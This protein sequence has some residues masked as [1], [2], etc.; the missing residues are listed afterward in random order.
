[1]T[2]HEVELSV[3]KNLIEIFDS[4]V[5]QFDIEVHLNGI[6]P[7]KPK[8]IGRRVDTGNATTRSGHS[9]SLRSLPTT[10]IEYGH[11]GLDLGVDLSG[12]DFLP[13]YVSKVS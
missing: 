10:N 3:G 7:T 12:N 4:T 6:P 1:V 5:V 9:Q 11:S 8:E 2:A 13:N